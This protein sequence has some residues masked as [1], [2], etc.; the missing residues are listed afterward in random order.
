[1]YFLTP[2]SSMPDHVDLSTTSDVI[3]HRQVRGY[4]DGCFDIMHS[5]HYNAI[6]QAK[7]QCD[8]LVVGI[9]SDEVIAKSKAPPVMKQE[10]RYELLKHI[11]WVDEILYDAPYDISLKTLEKARADFCVHGDDMPVDAS[12][13]GVYDELRDA[14]VLRIIKRT[15][16]VSTTDLVGRLLL[17]TK[18][19]L[20]GSNLDGGL[21]PNERSCVS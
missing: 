13:K 21:G 10:E 14:G 3:L 11:K 17:L 20:S 18:D 6:R 4:I 15:E 5:G 1:F 19:H 9:H 12:G 8:V 2:S 7:A 16:G